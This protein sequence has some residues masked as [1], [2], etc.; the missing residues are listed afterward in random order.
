MA[1]ALRQG[2]KDIVWA[3]ARANLPNM[4]VVMAPINKGALR[5]PIQCTFT[6]ALACHPRARVNPRVQNIL[7]NSANDLVR[8][9]TTNV[10]SGVTY[11]KFGTIQRRLAWPLHKD[12]TLFRVECTS[13]HNIYL[14]CSFLPSL[15]VSQDT[16]LSS[17]CVYPITLLHR[18]NEI[19]QLFFHCLNIIIIAIKCNYYTRNWAQE[20]ISSLG[21]L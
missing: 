2:A 5:P 7:Q 14:F 17:T 4:A 9:P 15:K 21:G 12:D 20:S 1:A 16:N 11:E 6:N 18:G 10:P 13:V 3:A 19:S 8:P